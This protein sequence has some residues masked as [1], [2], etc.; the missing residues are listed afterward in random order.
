MKSLLILIA[1]CV[2]VKT[3]AGYTFKAEEKKHAVQ[4]HDDEES[5]KIAL[6]KELE[7]EI[8]EDERMEARL[9]NEVQE[10]DSDN[11]EIDMEEDEDD[12]PSPRA[13]DPK[14]W[15]RRR[16]FRFRGRKFIRRIR[17]RGRKVIGFCAMNPHLCGLGK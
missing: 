10:E 15:G 13:N 3:S 16:W 4:G 11:D 14:P 17:I 1:V 6:M 7:D 8:E 12:S 9:K 2:L 5:K